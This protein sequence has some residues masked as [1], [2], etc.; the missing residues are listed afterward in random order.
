MIHFVAMNES[1]EKICLVPDPQSPCGFDPHQ[2]VYRHK[3][4]A[5]KFT[6]GGMVLAA[7]PI[8]FLEQLNAVPPRII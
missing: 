2:R 3:I 5:L 1:P 4:A 7:E 6:G 8:A